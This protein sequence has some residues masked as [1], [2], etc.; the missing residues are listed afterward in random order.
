[1]RLTRGV[2]VFVATRAPN[3][4]AHVNAGG[5]D[6][7]LILVDLKPQGIDGA[8]VQGVLD[9][10]S[11]TL[12]KN[13]VPG[14]AGCA[15]R[16]CGWR[17]AVAGSWSLGH[18][19][20]RHTRQPLNPRRAPTSCP[21]CCARATTP[22]GDKSAMV[23]GGMRIGTPALTTRGFKEA[24]FV[25]VCLRACACMCVCSRVCSRVCAHVRC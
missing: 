11:I 16:V 2:C 12:N 9:L 21:P 17:H 24:E 20:G 15:A 3:S 1:V 13:S 14:A 25:K 22:A 4:C 23:P 5:T 10:V 8:R 18:R 19:G 7:H 6:N